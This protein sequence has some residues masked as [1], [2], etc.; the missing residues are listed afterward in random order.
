MPASFLNE[1]NKLNGPIIKR[2]VNHSL[3]FSFEN[4]TAYHI[5]A[6]P[7]TDRILDILKA[8]LS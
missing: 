4:G 3:I 1:P 5:E 6:E 2:F 8:M 7:F